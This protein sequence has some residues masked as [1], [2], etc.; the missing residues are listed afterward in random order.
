M[1][2]KIVGSEPVTT[3]FGF[4]VGCILYLGQT[5]AKLPT[6]RQEWWTLL[7]AAACFAIGRMG[8]YSK[9][10][11]PLAIMVFTLGVIGL[12]GCGMMQ[13]PTAPAMS[14]AQYIEVMKLQNAAGCSV[15]TFRGTAT[16]YA[17]VAAK[18]AI[19]A[20][21]GATPPDLATCIGTL[22][23]TLTAPKAG[24]TVSPD[25]PVDRLIKMIE[26]MR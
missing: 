23:Q 19:I 13:L 12:T 21:Y 16:P 2:Q 4:L 3:G 18:A 15:A 6:N 26:E 9:A 8:G 7:I 1:Y 20:V 25:S 17:D 24:V 10:A 22:P 14:A 11:K 5:G